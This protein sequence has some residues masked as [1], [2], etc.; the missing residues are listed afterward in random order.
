MA[1]RKNKRWHEMC[2]RGAQVRDRETGEHVPVRLRSEALDFFREI[3]HRHKP[4][5]A[6]AHPSDR[7]WLSW[8][9]EGSPA[10]RQYHGPPP[11]AFTVHSNAEL[12]YAGQGQGFSVVRFDPHAGVLGTTIDPFSVSRVLAN[13]TKEEEDLIVRAFRNAI[14]DQLVL[15]RK[16]KLE[17][18]VVC[19]H[20]KVVLHAGDAY[21][22]HTPSLKEWVQ[23]FLT[24][25]GVARTQL[26]FEPNALRISHAEG[27]SAGFVERWREFHFVQALPRAAVVSFKGFYAAL[28]RDKERERNVQ[29]I[30]LMTLR[31]GR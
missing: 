6:V 22:V 7:A 29:D 15:F 17:Q 18:G 2:I 21:V 13:K 27:A 1:E 24:M 19:P 9:L 12:G 14:E 10:A 25:S 30:N 11:Y 4:Q 28:R 16:N 3:L 23:R 5:D 20:Q 8:L 26:K 31:T